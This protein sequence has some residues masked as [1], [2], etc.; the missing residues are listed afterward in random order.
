MP[1]E[2]ETKLLK[3]V[4]KTIFGILDEKTIKKKTNQKTTIA[5]PQ[6]ASVIEPNQLVPICVSFSDFNKM[7][8]TNA[9]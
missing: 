6:T 2:S 7:T 5:K 9:H 3:A 8:Q 4:I 1:V